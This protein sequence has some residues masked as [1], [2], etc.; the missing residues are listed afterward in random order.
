MTVN[1]DT[2]S[3]IEDYESDENKACEERREPKPKYVRAD[4]IDGP[5]WHS[6]ADVD[7]EPAVDVIVCDCGDRI[8]YAEAEEIVLEDDEQPHFSGNTICYACVRDH[9]RRGSR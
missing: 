1:T 3:S 8:R 2:S 4:G 6:V 9:D 7:Q 5:R